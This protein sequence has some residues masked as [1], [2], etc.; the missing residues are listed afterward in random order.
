MTIFT[1]DNQPVN[2]IPS[3]IYMGVADFSII[4]ADIAKGVIPTGSGIPFPLFSKTELDSIQANQNSELFNV[5]W[6]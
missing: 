6:N 1:S 3:S 4:L 2:T 5:P